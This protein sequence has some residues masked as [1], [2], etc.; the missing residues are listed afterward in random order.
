MISFERWRPLH[1]SVRRAIARQGHAAAAAVLVAWAGLAPAQAHA[2]SYALTDLGPCG[3]TVDGQ[4]LNAAG[5]VVWNASPDG[6][7]P[8]AYRYDGRAIQDLGPL[9]GAW[10]IARAINASDQVVGFGPYDVSRPIHAF[11]SDGAGLHDLG[12]LPGDDE[13]FAY[14]INAS[15]QVVGW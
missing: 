1:R 12:T 5:L 11:L 6:S 14:G 15:G 10:S 8:H 7:H 3:A 9:G 13:S 4:S 2:Q